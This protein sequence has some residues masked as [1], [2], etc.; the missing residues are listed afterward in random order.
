MKLEARHITVELGGWK[1]VDDVS[2]HVAPGELVGLQRHQT[3][4]VEVDQRQFAQAVG[5]V[6]IGPFGAQHANR[7]PRFADLAVELFD[8]GQRALGLVVFLIGPQREAHH[9]ESGQ[10]IE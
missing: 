6:E 8:L 3:Q 4:P 7:R 10:D 2:L 5:P 9:R 1:I